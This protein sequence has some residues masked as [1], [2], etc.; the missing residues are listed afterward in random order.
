MNLTGSLNVNDYQ[1]TSTTNL[2][3]SLVVTLAESLIPILVGAAV[4]HKSITHWQEKKDRIARK[5]HLLETY[6]QAVKSHMI[7]LE[8]FVQ[9]VFSSYITFQAAEAPQAAIMEFTSEKDNIRGFLKFPSEPADLPSKRFHLEYEDLA[10]EIANLSHPM[11]RLLLD[12]QYL[13]KN[14]RNMADGLQRIRE[15]QKR[16]ELVTASFLN[17]T[18]RDEFL[19]FRKRFQ[20]LCN[21]V[22]GETDKFE[23]ELA[24]LKL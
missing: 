12:I 5:N 16:A 2:L 13:P 1:M 9:R 20:T 22:K 21:E 8:N 11:D 4:G 6:S 3:L 18:T 10:L 24:G 7:L 17:S 15:L 23:N 19:A 14:Y